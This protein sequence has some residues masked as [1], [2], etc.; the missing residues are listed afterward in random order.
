M[1]TRTAEVC[2]ERACRA[3]EESIRLRWPRYGQVRVWYSTV[4]ISMLK[5]VTSRTTRSRLDFASSVLASVQAHGT[6]PYLPLMYSDDCNQNRIAFGPLVEKYRGR[7]FLIDGVHRSLA[8]YHA[9]INSIYVA[10]IEP[11]NSPPPPGPIRD[12]LGIVTLNT[13]IPR[14]PPFAGRASAYF[15]PSALFALDAERR[16]FRHGI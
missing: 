6:P 8:A 5:T 4:E 14:L 1:S 7:F 3:L 2:A 15:R 11:E 9:G 16:L 10:V 13:G 12:L